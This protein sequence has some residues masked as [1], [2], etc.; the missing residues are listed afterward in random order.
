MVV[1]AVS[2]TVNSFS[3]SLSY[4]C[5]LPL[6]SVKHGLAI[7]NDYKKDCTRELPRQPWLMQH[8]L[9]SFMEVLAKHAQ[10]YPRQVRTQCT[11]LSSRAA[12]AT[13]K[14]HRG[15]LLL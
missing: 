7:P 5:A 13:M 2:S 3:P 4:V 8:Q 9:A 15:T 14:G 10:C 6:P 12:A 11:Q 1:S